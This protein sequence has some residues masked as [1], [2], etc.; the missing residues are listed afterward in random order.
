VPLPSAPTDVHADPAFAPNAAWLLWHTAATRG[1]HA[2]IRDGGQSTSY[3]ELCD[4]AAATA[5]HLSSA[6]V[7][8]G[9][10]VAILLQRGADAAA[11]FFGILAAG[12]VAINVNE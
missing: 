9:D 2:A 5:A 11:A 6:G 10:R 8:P 3:A 4:A 12:A 1:A 7:E